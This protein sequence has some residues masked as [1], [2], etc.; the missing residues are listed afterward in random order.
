MDTTEL[1]NVIDIIKNEDLYNKRLKDLQAQEQSLK[2]TKFVVATVAQAN[3][4]R[5]EANELKAKGEALIVKVTK[6]AEEYKRALEREHGKDLAKLEVERET[7]I[8]M[9]ETARVEKAEARKQKE[10]AAKLQLDVQ[11]Q[12]DHWKVERD[13][14][15]KQRQTLKERVAAINELMKD[16]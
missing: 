7:I 3:K 2:D 11:Q 15:R 1:L 5:D 14:V 9:Q 10:E 13:E 12:Y 16:A 4:I 8:K 6:E